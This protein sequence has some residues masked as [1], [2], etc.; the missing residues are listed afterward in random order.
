MSDDPD[1]R[2]AGDRQRISLGQQHEV[3]YW[4][5]ELGVSEQQLREAIAKV[6]NMVS[7]V[8]GYLKG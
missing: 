3:E 1:N 2:G 6:G 8:R 4:S 7:D 5:Q